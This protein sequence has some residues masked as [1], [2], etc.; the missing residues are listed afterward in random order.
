M[1]VNYLFQLPHIKKTTKAW[2]FHLHAVS[3]DEQV[4]NYLIYIPVIHPSY[5]LLESRQGRFGS[6]RLSSGCSSPGHALMFQVL[7]FSLS[8]QLLTVAFYSPIALNW[9]AKFT[10]QR[11]VSMRIHLSVGNQILGFRI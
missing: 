4:L 8:C 6:I 5:L 11:L 10:Q 9:E 2:Y 3:L 7:P 1:I